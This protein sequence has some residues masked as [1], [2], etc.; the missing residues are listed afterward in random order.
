LKLNK[1][2]LTFSVGV[3]TG[4]AVTVRLTGIVWELLLAPGAE[5]AI[6]PV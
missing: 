3:L 6:D 5:M 4:A 2:G 1:P